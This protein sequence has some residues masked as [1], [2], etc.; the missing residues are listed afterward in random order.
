ML[1]AASNAVAQLQN[2]ASEGPLAGAG[3]EQRAIIQQPTIATQFW[4][5]QDG[6][7]DTK[8]SLVR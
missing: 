3:D 7:P 6:V 5:F 1:A 8:W 2:F 4:V